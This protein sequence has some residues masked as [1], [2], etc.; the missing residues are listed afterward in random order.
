MSERDVRSYRLPFEL[1]A[2]TAARHQLHD[3]LTQAGVPRRIVSD[4]ALVVSELVTNGVEHGRSDDDAIHV[5]WWMADGMLTLCVADDGS[6]AEPTVKQVDMYA[7]R[8][9]GLAL[10]ESICQSLSIDRTDGTRI[11]AQLKLG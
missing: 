2:A 1:A 11:T 6:E 5:S 8:G 9:R 4:A 3:F 10:V 7:P